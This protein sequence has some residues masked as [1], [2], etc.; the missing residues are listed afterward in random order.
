MLFANCVKMPLSVTDMYKSSR[1]FVWQVERY[2]LLPYLP[3]VNLSCDAPDGPVTAFGVG[4]RLYE[5]YLAVSD[6]FGME[7]AACELLTVLID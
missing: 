5:P 1:V 3:F 4:E 6:K 7:A 2:A